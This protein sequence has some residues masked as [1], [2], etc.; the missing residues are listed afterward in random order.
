MMA[1]TRYRMGDDFT[2]ADYAATGGLPPDAGGAV[3]AG[4]LQKLP[5]NNICCVPSLHVEG[6]VATTVGLGDAFVGGFLPA[7]L[8][9]M[10]T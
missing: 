7:L 2:A 3:L 4:E 10:A 5:G 1:A 6:S 9:C 8:S